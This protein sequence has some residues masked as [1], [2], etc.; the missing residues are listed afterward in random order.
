MLYPFTQYTFPPQNNLYQLP[1]GHLAG[2]YFKIEPGDLFVFQ[3]LQVIG[4]TEFVPQDQSIRCWI[5]RDLSGQSVH[6]TPP[7]ANMWHLSALLRDDITVYDVTSVDVPPNTIG[8]PLEPGWYWLNALNL[9]NQQNT[10]SFRLG[11]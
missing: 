6:L 11:E 5:S 8:V 10:F 9:V 3:M 2:F 1:S 7:T 4:T